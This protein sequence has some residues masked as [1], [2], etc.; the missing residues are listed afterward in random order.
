[1]CQGSQSSRE[2]SWA[3]LQQVYAAL[4]KAQ[5]EKQGVSVRQLVEE[6]KIK[7][8][9]RNR[10]YERV[11]EGSLPCK[12][13]N[14]VLARLD[15]DQIRAALTVRCFADPD[16]YEDPC[17]ETTAYVAEAF[18]AYLP[19]EMAACEGEFDG[20]RKSLCEG[21]AKRAIS[22]IARNHARVEAQREAIIEP[23]HA[24]G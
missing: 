7:A 2:E 13:L 6:R 17:C 22:A 11:A 12:E 21:L 18:A 24:F 23:D 9:Q 1:M 3:K 8:S 4:I 16:A 10:F 15:I 14:K 19:E 5:M 20:L